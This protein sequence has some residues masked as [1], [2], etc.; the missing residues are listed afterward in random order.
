MTAISEVGNRLKLPP[1]LPTDYF[2][3]GL[4]PPN[5]PNLVQQL[6]PQQKRQQA[7]QGKTSN[8]G[9]STRNTALTQAKA[10]FLNDSGE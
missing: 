8:T 5:T 1:L 9:T 2:E 4:T 7:Q 6:T 3:L 10:E